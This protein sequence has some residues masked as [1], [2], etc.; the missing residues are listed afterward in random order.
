MK[1]Y[2]DVLKR[3]ND[4]NRNRISLEEL[5]NALGVQTSDPN[6][7]K[8]LVGNLSPFWYIRIGDY[9]IIYEIQEESVT[10]EVIKIRHCKE[11]Y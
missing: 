2:Y 5:E 7:G 11:V 6:S 9:R 4:E 10:V 3:Q 1:D 8:K